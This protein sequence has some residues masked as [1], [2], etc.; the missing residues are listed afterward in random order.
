MRIKNKLK[1]G[2]ATCDSDDKRPLVKDLLEK[3]ASSIEAVRRAILSD[4]NGKPLFSSDSDRYDDIW[5]LRFVLSHKGNAK[6]A[7]KAALDTLQFREEMKLNEK[8]DIRHQIRNAG[9]ESG[10][11]DCDFGEDPLFD[12]INPHCGRNSA[13]TTQPDPD[14]GP[15]VYID[16]REFDQEGMLTLSEDDYRMAKVLGNER[17]YQVI[18]EVTRRTGR[19][20]KVT[21]FLDLEGYSMNREYS[22]RDTRL[23]Q[24]LQDFYPQLVAK[25]YMFNTPKW[26]AAIWVVAKKVLPK[27]LT[28]KFEF[29]PA[30]ASEKFHEAIAEHV[31]EDHLPERYGGKERRWPLP[32]IGEQMAARAADSGMHPQ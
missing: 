23:N 11:C 21:C 32:S 22:A 17:M 28:E 12:K 24:E 16:V 30:S 29:L 18:D 7:S 27:R 10:S 20:T 2:V 19:L 3:H 14:R 25:N 9:V 8:G 6:K 1:K 5:I 31:S 4:E 15:I 13:I 26:F